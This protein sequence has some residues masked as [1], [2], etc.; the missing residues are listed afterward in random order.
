MSPPPNTA[1]PIWELTVG[2]PPSNGVTLISAASSDRPRNMMP[3]AVPIITSVW[4]A[5]RHSGLRKAGTPLEIASTP[6]TAAGEGVEHVEHPDAHEQTHPG[7]GAPVQLAATLGWSPELGQIPREVLPGPDAEQEG[8]G[9]DEE[10][11]RD[12][13]D[14]PRLSDTPQVA[15]GDEADEEDRDQD[16]VG[17]EGVESR[18]ER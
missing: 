7:R 4:R 9:G 5:L 3:R 18:C 12:G 13:K 14:P 16:A 17:L 6:G 10:V 2:E 8:H 15:V 1:S 11:G